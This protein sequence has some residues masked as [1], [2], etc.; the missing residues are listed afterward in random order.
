MLAKIRRLNWIFTFSYH[1]DSFWLSCIY[2]GRKKCNT[3]F[4]CPSKTFFRTDKMWT[5]RLSGREMEC[6]D[7]GTLLYTVSLFYTAY[8]F[9]FVRL[10][11][12]DSICSSLSP[13]CL[14]FIR[15]MSSMSLFVLYSVH[16]S[17]TQSLMNGV[18]WLR[19]TFIY[20]LLLL[21]CSI[22]VPL[23]VFVLYSVHHSVT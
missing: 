1:I 17:V 13:Y 19:Y 22:E 3:F 20:D 8:C 11:L 18:Y 14:F 2:W 23:W 9:F 15:M 4:I 5:V 16:Y 21:F 10:S 7:C 6:T 12:Y